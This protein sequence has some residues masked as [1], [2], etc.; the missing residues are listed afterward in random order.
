MLTPK[1]GPMLQVAWV[2]NDLDKAMSR[3]L[4]TQS[5]GPFYVMRHCPLENVLYRGQPTTVDIDV[6]IAQA[7][8]VQIELIQQNDAKPSCYRDMFAVGAEGFHH[9]CYFVDDL[10]GAIA[11][12]AQRDQPVAIQGNFGAVEFAYVDSRSGVGCMTEL[13]GRHP[14]IESFFKM[15]ADAAVDWNG[16]DPIRTL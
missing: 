4:D 7:G 6:G 3:W 8:G 15:I 12:F 1:F 16:K 5:V 13:V 11:H 9:V 14:D 10:K 2:V